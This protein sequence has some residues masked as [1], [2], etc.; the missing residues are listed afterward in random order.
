MQIFRPINRAKIFHM[1]AR[2]WGEGAFVLVVLHLSVTKT[3][4]WPQQVIGER[5]ELKVSRAQDGGKPVNTTAG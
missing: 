4:R 3:S 2:R 5:G 1:I